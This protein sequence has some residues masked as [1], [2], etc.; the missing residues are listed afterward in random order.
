M[1][2]ITF[3]EFKADLESALGARS[4]LDATLGR[5]VN[6]AYYDLAGSIDFEEFDADST[7]PTVGGT[8]HITAPTN[9]QVIQLVK[10]T[11]NDALL[12][13][14]PK[15]E[16]YR[17]AVITTGAPR[18]WTRHGA[19]I[20]LNPTP[21]GVVNLLVIYKTPPAVLTAAAVT[22]IS[23]VW[24]QAIFFLSVHQGL[25]ALGEE[26]RA[27]VW[28]QR[29]VTYIQTRMTEQDLHFVKEGLGPS[30]PPLIA[31]SQAQGS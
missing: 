2:L 7:I 30:L 11:T 17:R 22:T 16:F 20:K 12:G 25:L 10:D 1:G 29:A 28:L 5:W 4:I 15:S 19:L 23:A 8:P 24:D 6:Y 27:T 14:I 31:R 26:A 3:T 13:W 21:S 18:V 9:S